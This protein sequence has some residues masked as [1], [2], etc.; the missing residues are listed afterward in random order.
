MCCRCGCISCH[1][2]EEQEEECELGHARHFI[3]KAEKA[4]KLK[5]YAEELRKEIAAVEEQITELES[6]ARHLK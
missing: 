5:N 4:E 6:Q 3:T 1:H 2:E